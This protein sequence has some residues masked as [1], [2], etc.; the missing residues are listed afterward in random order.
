[1]KTLDTFSMNLSAIH[2]NL[3]PLQCFN[4]YVSIKT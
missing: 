1:M 3:Q 2:Q 4:P